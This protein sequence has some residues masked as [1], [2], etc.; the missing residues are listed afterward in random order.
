MRQ[1]F[2]ISTTETN[3]M[4]IITMGLPIRV[5]RIKARQI[6]VPKVM[7]TTVEIITTDILRFHLQLPLQ[8]PLR[9]QPQLSHLR[10]RPHQ[11]LAMTRISWIS[12]S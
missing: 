7:A 8:L 10:Q 2:I 11:C 9:P 5:L 3:I 4:E 6:M 12:N 1:T